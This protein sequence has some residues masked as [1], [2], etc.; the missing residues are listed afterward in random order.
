MAGPMIAADLLDNILDTGRTIPL[1]KVTAVRPKWK[2]D[3]DTRHMSRARLTTPITASGHTSPEAKAGK[4]AVEAWIEKMGG[5]AKALKER[6]FNSAKA[7]LTIPVEQMQRIRQAYIFDAMPEENIPF[8]ECPVPMTATQAKE[9]SNRDKTPQWRHDRNRTMDLICHQYGIGPM[10]Q[11]NEAVRYLRLTPHELL[12]GT[13][14]FPF[15][16]L[17]RK[18]S[19]RLTY[20]AGRPFIWNKPSAMFLPAYDEDHCKEMS[21]GTPIV[22]GR[23]CS[24]PCLLCHGGMW[25]PDTV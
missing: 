12:K 9:I 17:L 15:D 5:K 1:R 24:D 11:E 25:H 3:Q 14:E 18:T 2:Y 10:E 19:E 13:K 21:C 4:A 22:G 7:K 20:V 8:S 16:G 6:A 23:G